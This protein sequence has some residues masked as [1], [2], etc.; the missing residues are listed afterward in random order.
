MPD[1]Y[2]HLSRADQEGI[3]HYSASA[4]RK[5]GIVLEKDIWVCWV[6]KQIFEMP[7]RLS[8]AFKG[9]TSLSKIYNVIDRFSEDIDITLDYRQ[10]DVCK[11]LS[12]GPNETVPESLSR[13]A[14]RRLSDALKLNV[15]EYSMDV[16]VPYLKSQIE[17]L[18]NSDEFEVVGEGAEQI[19]FIYPS[20]IKQSG[21]QGY[22]K[23]YVLIEFGGRN[24][25]DPSDTHFV[26]PDVAL[27]IDTVEFPSSH[28]VVLSPERTFWEKATL[29]H[30]ECNRGV[31]ENAERLSR[32]WFDLTSL[33]S[34]EIG[35]QA[36]QN[37][38]LL[39]DVISLKS[40]FFN[41]SYAHYG[42]CL[43]GSFRLVPD[44][45]GLTH[46]ETDFSK[47]RDA[48]MLND[49]S[50]SFEEVIEHIRTIESRMNQLIA[51]FLV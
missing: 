39:K 36:I 29:I 50:M 41:A 13:N 8:M 38:G 48:G 44:P 25:I 34:H 21:R 18:P 51:D 16:V 47:M 30:V 24:I 15:Q 12:L 4:F 43:T 32:H 22:I 1:N 7:N 35:L 40:I 28:V 46:L 42:E 20:A 10:F 49:S 33:Y 6:L 45:E 5:N 17:L 26:Q 3:L 37:I 2:T 19:R 14:I 27:K 23:D 9:G 11:S 31:R